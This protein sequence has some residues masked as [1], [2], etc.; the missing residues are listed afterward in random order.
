MK[1]FMQ[2]RVP[3]RAA[4]Y[5]RRDAAQEQGP[6]KKVCIVLV[7]LLSVLFVIP[8]YGAVAVCVDYS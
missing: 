4:S 7:S 8:F 3:G 5:H 2:V 6:A 1:T